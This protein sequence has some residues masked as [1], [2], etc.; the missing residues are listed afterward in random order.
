[1]RFKFYSNSYTFKP[2]IFPFFAFITALS[3]LL[4]LSAWQF[5]RLQWKSKLITERI[6]SF[7]QNPINFDNIKIPEENEFR[8][9][10]VRGKLLNDQEM[11]MPALSKRGNNG[12]HIL[13]PIKTDNGRIII[14]NTGWVP[15][16]K[17]DKELRK[18]NIFD[19]EKIFEAV[20]RTS[21]RKGYFQPEN[22][23]ETNTWFFVEPKLMSKYTNLNF[24]KGYYLEATSNGPNGFPL[25]NQTRIYLRNNHLQYALTWL[26]IA[27]GLIG[28]FFFANI[29]KN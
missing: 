6:S 10:T 5:K 14:F 16:K 20:I 22:D 18:T 11:Y 13:V 24:E 23:I 17:K 21:G 8:K 1:M 27:T 26:M 29:K 7:E 19:N 15:L 25:G 3:I 28:V 2:R 4:S 9:V 12:F